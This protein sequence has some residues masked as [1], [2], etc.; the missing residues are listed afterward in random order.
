MKRKSFNRALRVSIVAMG[1]ASLLPD[2]AM[3]QS[4]VTLY[5]GIDEGIDYVNNSAGS[6]LVRLRD[7]TWDG[8]LGS[9]FGLSGVE[10]L[11]GGLKTVFKLEAGFDAT[12]GESLQGSREFGRLAYVGLADDRLGIVTIGRQYDFMTDYMQPVTSAGQFGGPF[13]H[14]GDI[15]NTA[16]SFRLNNAIRYASPS[17]EGVTFGG[18]YAFSDAGAT[19]T[20]TTGTWAVAATYAGA[21]IKLATVFQHTNNPAQQF[22]EGDFIGNTTGTAIGASGPF[23][24]VGTPRNEQIIG[25]GG[26]YTFGAAT[27]GLSFTNTKFDDANGTTSSVTF[28]NYDVWAKYDITPRTT[29]GGAFVYSSGEVNYNGETPKYYLVGLFSS[30]SLSK[31][32]VLYAMGAVQQA[33]GSAANADIFDYAIAD[34]STTNRQLMTRIGMYHLF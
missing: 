14:A 15:D 19:G 30:Y 33:G 10:D 23:S 9:R 29:V 24:Y 20:G 31:T 16:N 4:S 32:T 12:N 7:G 25:V 13:V 18:L 1:L 11:G 34:A 2:L 6:S 8:M 22:D 3:A 28:D 17:F 26:S 5:G 27:A 21:G